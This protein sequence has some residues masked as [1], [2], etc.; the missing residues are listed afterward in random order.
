MKLR[1][2]RSLLSFASRRSQHL[3]RGEYELPEHPPPPKTAHESM[4]DTHRGRLRAVDRQLLCQGT[5]SEEREGNERRGEHSVGDKKTG[6]EARSQVWTTTGTRSLKRARKRGEN[7]PQ[8][9]TWARCQAEP[10]TSSAGDWLFPAGESEPPCASRLE[11]TGDLSLG[12]GYRSN[13]LSPGSAS[14][15]KTS[16][17]FPIPRQVQSYSSPTYNFAR[18]GFPLNSASIVRFEILQFSQPTHSPAKPSPS[19]KAGSRRR[20]RPRDVASRLRLRPH[21]L[22]RGLLFT[23]PLVPR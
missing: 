15:S 19:R 12:L 5:G 21:L 6:R 2:L 3:A 11:L 22:P 18:A 17:W 23:P 14:N 13:H 7:S 10:N 9:P 8:L 1:A 4:S 16:L 20:T